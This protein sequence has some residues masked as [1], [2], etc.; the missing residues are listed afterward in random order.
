MKNQM[1]LVSNKDF[2]STSK[3]TFSEIDSVQS[4][5]PA[6]ESVDFE[7]NNLSST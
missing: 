5:Q 2:D 6:V 3:L 1:L 4:H 7:K